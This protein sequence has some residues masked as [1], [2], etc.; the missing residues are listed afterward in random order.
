MLGMSMRMSRVENSDEPFDDPAGVLS[1]WGVGYGAWNDDDIDELMT[2]EIEGS[3]RVR[4]T[5]G[6]KGTSCCLFNSRSCPKTC[7]ILGYMVAPRTPTLRIA[8]PSD[9]NVS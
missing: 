3:W 2:M 7:K 9:V 8:V 4:T 5:H 1:G 6:S